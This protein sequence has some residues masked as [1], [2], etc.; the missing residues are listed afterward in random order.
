MDRCKNFASITIFEIHANE[1][2]TAKQ[3]LSENLVAL[4]RVKWIK[5]IF[6]FWL[7]TNAIRQ[8]CK[9]QKE[10]HSM[11]CRQCNL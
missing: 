3:G 1:D 4:I 8:T 5:T 10:H 2:L 6:N 7:L 11:A 9:D